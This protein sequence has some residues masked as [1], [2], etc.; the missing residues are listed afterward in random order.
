MKKMLYTNLIVTTNQ[1]LLIDMQRIKRK[2]S[3][4]VTKESQQ[5]MKE[6]KRR[7]DQRKT[8]KTMTKQVTE[9]Q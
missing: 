1:K 6:S 9:R 2:E 7:K 4:Y 8:T 3:K 5:S